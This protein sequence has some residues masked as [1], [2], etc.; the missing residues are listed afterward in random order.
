MQTAISLCTYV[1]VFDGCTCIHKN[2]VHIV[3]DPVTFHNQM[4]IG[5]G[6]GLRPTGIRSTIQ[7]M[8]DNHRCNRTIDNNV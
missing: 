2:A 3:E 7:Q 5:A 1:S 8:Q 6:D 4:I